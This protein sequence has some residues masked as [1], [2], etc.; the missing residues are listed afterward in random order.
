MGGSVRILWIIAIALSLGACGQPVDITAFHTLSGNL[1]GKSFEMAPTESQQ[2][3]LEWQTYANMVA[4]NLEA[5]G[6]RRV[7]AQGR[8]DY[9]VFVAHA[10]GS[11]RTSVSAM[12]MFGQ[13]SAG[14]TTTT[15]SYVGRWPV[16]QT[17]YT[18][19][20]YGVTGY[21]PVSSTTFGKILKISMMDIK[22]SVAERTPVTVYE[23]TVTSAG[24]SASLNRA[25]P[26][27][28]T[29]M[30]QDWPGKSGVTR[31]VEIPEE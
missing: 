8:A 23:A 25:I 19:P 10:V 3:S 30:F 26:A 6:L 28:V 2:G 5:K 21:Y 16:Q 9:V 20:T 4:S 22:K 12:P 7:G 17:S 27:M 24:S 13:T 15:T 1:A 14:T 31:H 29:A 18:P 11:G